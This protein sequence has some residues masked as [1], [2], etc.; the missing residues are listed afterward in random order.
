MM[1]R[2]DN[3]TDAIVNIDDTRVEGHYK[4]FTLKPAYQPIF[5]IDSEGS[6]NLTGFEGLVR[7]YLDGTVMD[8]YE[9]FQT[10]D[11][12]DHLFVECMCMALHI[13][14]Y[15][16]VKPGNK[17]LFINVDVSRF[18]SVDALETEI[19]YTFSQLPKNGLNRQ[20]VVFE[21][22]ET[23]VLEKQ[24][25]LRI[26]EMFRNNGFRFA[27]DDFGTKHS[28][29]ERFLMVKPDIVKLDRAIFQNVS[30]ASETEKLLSALI[31]AF[32]NNGSQVLM[33]GIEYPEEL[34]LAIDMDIDMMQGYALAHPELLPH[35]FEDRMLFSKFRR[36]TDLKLVKN[37][38]PKSAHAW[39][40]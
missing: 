28:N 9:F 34:S 36:K 8:A 11:K 12:K 38:E 13:R 2:P 29:I 40:R 35:E 23:E 17:L 27:L 5:G 4:Y 31:A 18:P 26:C 14:S 22:L 10:V 20:R 30:K 21:I 37:T 6:W 19:F 32:R 1:A 24:V 25:M 39:A 16:Y 15:K 7:P 3:V 33:E